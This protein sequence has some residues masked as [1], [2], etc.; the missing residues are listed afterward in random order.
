MDADT[1]QGVTSAIIQWTTEEI[2]KLATRFVNR[3]LAFVGDSG[4]IAIVKEQ[5]NSIE[6]ELYSEF[7]KDKKLRTLIQMGLTL[8]SFENEHD[9]RENQKLAF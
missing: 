3:D 9:K 2:K 4:T 1:I 6:W 7:I 5:R 8:R